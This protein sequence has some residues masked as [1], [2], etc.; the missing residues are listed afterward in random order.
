M[1]RTSSTPCTTT[2][3][4]ASASRCRPS[5]RP[6]A[7][8]PCTE[9]HHAT[10]KRS[11]ERRPDGRSTPRS[12]VSPATHREGLDVTQVIRAVST[13]VRGRFRLHR[14]QGRAPSPCC[15]PSSYLAPCG[16]S[17]RARPTGPD[18]RTPFA[19][20]PSPTGSRPASSRTSWR[21]GPG[22]GRWRRSIAS[23]GHL[24]DTDATDEREALSAMRAAAIENARQTRTT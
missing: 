16:R 23:Y 24:L 2:T 18:R 1:T 22:T 7:A 4:S 10:T 17:R 19:T 15:V 20:R 8:D 21:S 11:V 12:R 3:G 5:R 13:Q 14:A 9:P 6:T